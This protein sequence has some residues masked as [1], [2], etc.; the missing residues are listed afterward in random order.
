MST[1]SDPALAG[2]ADVAAI[3]ALYDDLAANDLEALWRINHKLIPFQPRPSADAWKWDYATLLALAERAG[4]LVP[5]DRGGDRR[6]LGCINPGLKR[7][8]GESV[9]GAT[10]SLWAAIQYLGP[11]ESAPGHRHSPSALRFVVQGSGAWTTVDGER[12]AMTR[13][14]LV[15]TP[16]YAWHDH[17]N[18][19]DEAMVWFD[20]LDLP[21]ACFLDA[22]FLEFPDGD[23]M[24][25]VRGVHASERTY[26][27]AGLLPLAV[28]PVVGGSGASPLPEGVI[29]ARRTPILRYPWERTRA[30]LE[31]LR[32]DAWDDH[33]GV[34]LRYTDPRTG[35]SIMPTLDAAIQLLPAGRSTLPHRHVHSAVYQVFEG[36]G[37]T[38]IDGI[39]FDWEPGDII[40]LPPWSVHEHHAGEA[41]A[42]LFSITD[43]PVVTVLGFERI[44]AG[45]TPQE[46]TGSFSGR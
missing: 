24:Q 16:A 25:E 26:A 33:D 13:G 29:A 44:V 7:A 6:V 18:D 11:H 3:E 43:A 36:S 14:D 38:V 20:G 41:D 42:L 46:V 12:C 22:Q 31:G 8:Y 10:Q 5:I 19:S 27:A 4:D 40:A 35:G 45:D 9:Y 30:A 21:L 23:D 39:R 37:H 2:G 15:V 17:T 28:P 1:V 32:S 34:L